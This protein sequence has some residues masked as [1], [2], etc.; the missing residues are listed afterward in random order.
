MWARRASGGRRAGYRSP[1]ARIPAGVSQH[2]PGPGPIRPVSASPACRHR[3]V[4]AA[5]PV[6]P[7]SQGGGEQVIRCAVHLAGQDQAGDIPAGQPG[8]PGIRAAAGGRVRAVA[9]VD[10]LVGAAGRAGHVGLLPDPGKKVA[11]SAR[12]G[13]PTVERSAGLR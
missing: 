9:A 8:H 12:S 2:H 6:R 1:A 3:A 4:I 7:H 10:M 5:E 11:G 13:P